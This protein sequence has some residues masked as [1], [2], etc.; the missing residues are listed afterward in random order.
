[1]AMK[2]PREL[3]PEGYRLRCAHS[4]GGLG[5]YYYAERWSR[6]RWLKRDRW[7][8]IE[9]TRSPTPEAALSRLLQIV[10]EDGQWHSFNVWCDTAA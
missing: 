2:D 4:D 1:M 7:D 8:E 6:T 9:G 10:T 3:C 5:L